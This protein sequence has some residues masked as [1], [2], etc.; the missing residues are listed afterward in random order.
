LLQKDYDSHD[1]MVITALQVL[2][3]AAGPQRFSNLHRYS[4]HTNN[5]VTKMTVGDERVAGAAHGCRLAEIQQPAQGQ[6]AFAQPC[7]NHD[8]R[9]HGNC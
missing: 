4:K 5:V 2:P 1:C 8:S 9:L 7:Y 6:Q 3:M